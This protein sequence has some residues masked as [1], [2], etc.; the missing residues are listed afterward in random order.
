[1]ILI[2]LK[3]LGCVR[4][5]FIKLLENKNYSLLWLGQ[6]VSDLVLSI[7]YIGLIMTSEMKLGLE[8]INK[9]EIVKFVIMF[10]AISAR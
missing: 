9:H 6:S 7:N 3:L 1:M 10:F 2:L 4:Q 8:Y 5:D